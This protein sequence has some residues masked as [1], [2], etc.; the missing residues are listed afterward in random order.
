M[1]RWGGGSE[2]GAAH[3]HSPLQGAT[4]YQIAR[5]N[6]GINIFPRTSRQYPI[7]VCVC[8]SVQCTPWTAKQS[9]S[10]FLF[11]LALEPKPRNALSTFMS[12]IFFVVTFHRRSW[13]AHTHTHTHSL[14]KSTVLY[15]ISYLVT[16]T[17]A[18]NDC[19]AFIRL[20]VAPSQPCISAVITIH[21]DFIPSCFNI[22]PTVL[23]KKAAWKVQRQN[24]TSE[25]QGMEVKGGAPALAVG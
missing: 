5:T 21:T 16:P 9:H 1:E 13:G 19:L 8:T 25:T 4:L 2:G 17:F 15:I 6:Q 22:Q 7:T 18:A 24:T 3:S 23:C 11:P 10:F 20:R 12:N 14:R